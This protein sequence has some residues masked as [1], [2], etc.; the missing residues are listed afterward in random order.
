[1]EKVKGSEHFPKALYN[2]LDS[3]LPAFSQQLSAERNMGT[4]YTGVK[5]GQIQPSPRPNTYEIQA[6]LR[7]CNFG[8]ANFKWSNDFFFFTN[9][10]KQQQS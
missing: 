8:Y 5:L 2:S 6:E 10:S 3:R 4:L 9:T 7:P 1:M